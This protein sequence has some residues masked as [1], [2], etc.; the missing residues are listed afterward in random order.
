MAA[1]LLRS[2]TLPARQNVQE[3]WCCIYREHT[4][5]GAFGMRQSAPILS[6]LI[7]LGII[8]TLAADESHHKPKPQGDAKPE[9]SQSSNPGTSKPD[10]AAE[11]PKE[12]L[13]E[14]QHTITINGAEIKYKA[15]VGNL[16][17]KADDDEEKPR[18]NMF[19][20]AYEKSDV[21]DKA[22]RPI[23]FA[24]N[25]GPGSSSVWLHMGAFGP[26]RIAVGDVNED[27]NPPYRL[28]DNP[29]SI[30]DL[31]DLVFIDPVATGYS[32]PA[33]GH[34]DNEFHGL[35]EDIHSVGDFIRLYVTRFGRWESPK[36]LAGE[37]YGTTR[38]AGLAGYLQQSLGMNLNG[39]VLVSTVLNFETI[40]AG[41]G[42]DLAYTLFLPSFTE[43][44]WYHKRLA[45]ELQADVAKARKEVEAFIQE[46]YAPA[47]MR[48][49]RLPAEDEKRIVRKLARYT[50]LSEDYVRRSNLR[51]SQ[52]RFCKELLRS[53]GKT[54]GRYDG[55][56]TGKDLDDAGE[57]SEY[58]PS[59]TAVHGPFTAAVNQYLHDELNYKNDRQYKILAGVSW[60]WGNSGHAVN[61]A[62][63]LRKNMTENPNLQVFVASGWYDLA[64]PYFA[65]KY[66]LDHLGADASILKRITLKHYDAG[67]MMYVHQPCLLQLKKDLAAFMEAAVK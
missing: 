11:A 5:S 56:Y 62:P 25:G 32:R 54:L 23:L 63:T 39:I 34:K 31:S 50:G 38:A 1:R 29:G 8:A 55:R 17:L 67:H 53:E 66:T 40:Q 57:H 26:R 65:T 10:S 21:K 51:I 6:V 3:A 24:F 49:L 61:V 52:G 47:L 7:I 58:D 41:E 15:T 22:K 19:F 14:T 45:P 16:V 64:T 13:T 9:P 28:T 44:A 4:Y 27:V 37:S 18:A 43:V 59:Y 35:Q 60:N 12:S 2:L 48:G 46:E 30:L 20:I 36:F 42:N 33:P